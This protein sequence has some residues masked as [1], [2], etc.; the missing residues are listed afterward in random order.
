MKREKNNVFRCDNRK[1]LNII[2]TS[3]DQLNMLERE[4]R[5]RF[6]DDFLDGQHLFE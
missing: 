6:A 3:N 2:K 4:H 1:A 5:A